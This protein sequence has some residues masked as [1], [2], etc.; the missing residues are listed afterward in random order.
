VKKSFRNKFQKKVLKIIFGKKF[1][2]FKE[3]KEA[4]KRN[5]FKYLDL[6]TLCFMVV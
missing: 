5:W 2:N 3:K 4:K 6:F 1:E